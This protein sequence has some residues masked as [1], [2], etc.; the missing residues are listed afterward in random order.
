MSHPMRRLIDVK[1]GEGRAVGWTWLYFYAVL[2]SYY[3]LRPIRDEAGVAGGVDNLPWLFTGTLVAMA[4]ANPAF[5]TLVAKLPRVRFVSWTYRFFMVNL[6]VFFLLLQ[7]TTG[8]QN[9]WVGRVF[10]V[11][12]AVFNLFVPSVFWAFMSDV[13]TRDQ[14]GRLFGVIAAAGTL[15][16]VTGATITATLAQVFPP[17]YLLLVSAAL[18]EVSVV[19]VHRLSRHS[20]RLRAA[21]GAASQE[22][23]IGGGILAGVKH[24]MS[25]SYLL[26]VCVYMLIYTFLNTVLYFQ[27]SDIVEATFVDRAARTAF[28]ARIDLITQALT[29]VLQVF[30]LGGMLKT[31]GVALTLG[32]LPAVSAA[33]FLALA[34]VPTVAGV[35][36]LNVARRVG[37]FAVARPTREVLFTVV[38]REDRYK[39]KNFID[40]VVY[41]A[42]DQIGAWTYALVAMLGFGHS[43]L[44]AIAVGLA[45]LWLANA[46]WLGRRQE[47]MA[48]A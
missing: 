42:G 31:L 7:G 38:P 15:G 47:A 46:W 19:A 11:W 16:A 27:Q 24:A 48:R 22:V 20:E 13:F 29:F 14:A 10:F 32:V 2:A 41:R 23:P 8:E 36:W 4:L 21:R 6:L 25:S 12:T 44:A 1:P 17:M 33:G 26:N 45:A 40:T 34:L 5:S 3:V 39:A 28:F 43:I 18:L 30:A 9:V 37:N 35:V